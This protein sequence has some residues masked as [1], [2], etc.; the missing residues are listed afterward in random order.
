MTAP[1]DRNRVAPASAEA[2]RQED[3]SGGPFGDRSVKVWTVLGGI[4]SVVAV[5]MGIWLALTGG[6]GSPPPLPVV[7]TATPSSL[8]STA[9][10][11]PSPPAV[12]T[13]P[14]NSDG[15]L[16]K[17]ELR[18]QSVLNASV[19]TDCTPR[20]PPA[21]GATVSLDCAAVSSGPDRRPLISQFSSESAIESVMTDE[22]QG[23]NSSGGSCENGNEYVGTWRGG[24]V[25]RG[26]LV[27]KCTS[28]Q[29]FRIAWTYYDSSLFVAAESADAAQLGQWWV[30]NLKVYR[31]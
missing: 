13:P 11:T 10:V 25:E 17:S 30:N 7:T 6:A 4:G 16:A 9:T 3:T 26:E 5:A 28:R 24:G 27:C 21:T 14:A 1:D 12:S 18:L 22:A 19:F 23:V 2:P 29:T 20:R 8:P 31:D 15:E